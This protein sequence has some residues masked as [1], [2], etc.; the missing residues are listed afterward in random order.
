MKKIIFT[1]LTLLAMANICSAQKYF[2]K[3]KISS[4]NDSLSY[5]IGLVMAESLGQQGFNDLNATALGK[6]FADV[7]LNKPTVMNNEQAEE[8]IHNYFA[9]V[10]AEKN[11]KAKA[12]EQ[13]FLENNL[14]EPGVK[15]TESGLQ[16]IVIKEGNGKR[17]TIDNS[18]KIHYE[19]KLTNGMLFDSDFENDEPTQFNL[20]NLISGMSEGIMLMSEGSEYTFYIPSELGYGEFSPAEEIPAYSTLV[21]NVVLIS[22]E[23][24]MPEG[25]YDVDIDDMEKYFSIEESESDN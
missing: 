6:A 8:F 10:T 25:Q 14:K 21:F 9:K 4:G 3:Q 18:V 17:P 23:D 2:D 20:D 15:V 19:G 7:Q 22:V 1:M 13:Q 11:E 16:Y 5:A 12:A 24:K